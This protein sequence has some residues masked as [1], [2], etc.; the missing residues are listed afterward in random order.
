MSTWRTRNGKTATADAVE[1][2][3]LRLVGRVE[4]LEDVVKWHPEKGHCDG[5]FSRFHSLRIPKPF[6]SELKEWD[7]LALDWGMP[8]D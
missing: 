1:T 6:G 7:L 2:G 8:Q 4:G 3:P 5:F